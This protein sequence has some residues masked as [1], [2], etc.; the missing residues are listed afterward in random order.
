MAEEATGRLPLRSSE[1]GW[2]LTELWVTGDLLDPT[3]VVEDNAVI[4]VLDVLAEELPWLAQHPAGEWV[5]DVLRAGKRPF[6]WSYRSQHGPVGNHRNRRLVRFWCAS[7]GLDEEVIEGLRHRRLV[8][9]PVVEVADDQLA[10]ELPA[11]LER[12]R[13]HLRTVVDGYWS[14]GWRRAHKG[15]DRSPEDTLWRAASAVTEMEEALAA[16][17]AGSGV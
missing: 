3:D 14:P 10:L 4:L 7:S 15:Y 13:R 5:G 1:L 12:S 8:E 17:A 6:L 2:P 9:L 16:I 11:E